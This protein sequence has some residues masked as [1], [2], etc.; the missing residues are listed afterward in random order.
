[1]PSPCYYHP[2][3]TAGG[4]CIQCGIPACP[5][6]LEPVGGRLACRR[7]SPALKER[8]SALPAQPPVAP[9][10]NPNHYN[11]N[12]GLSYASSPADYVDTTPRE[13]L[14]AAMLL[15]GIAIA[16]VVGVLGAIGVEKV[17]FY[18]HH[19]FA[20]LYLMLG[21][22]VGIALRSCTSRG[23]VGIAATAAVV[24]ALCLVVSHLVY[25]QDILTE[26]R[27]SGNADPGV[28]FADA[29]PFAMAR[30]TGIHWLLVV[31]SIGSS[32]ST[33]YRE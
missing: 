27:A 14:S 21:F 26:A 5:D 24:M 16:A 31:A 28:T 25:V 20:F 15:K 32:A 7:C 11:P 33:A 10:Y 18:S 22:G 17:L 29:F 30:L 13:K 2:A 23:G 12:A 6:C 19:G 3:I 1:M 4:V 9:V 8:Q